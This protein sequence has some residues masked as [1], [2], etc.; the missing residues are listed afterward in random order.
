MIGWWGSLMIG[1]WGDLFNI[2]NHVVK[3]KNKKKLQKNL[4]IKNWCCNFAL[5]SHVARDWKPERTSVID[6]G[7]LKHRKFGC[8]GIKAT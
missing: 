1:W 8:V 4:E 7:M 2:D 5:F 6:G 3:K